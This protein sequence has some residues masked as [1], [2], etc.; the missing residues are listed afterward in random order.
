[1]VNFDELLNKSLSQPQNLIRA[2]FSGVNM[3]NLPWIKV[4]VR[5]VKIKENLVWQF[6]YFDQKKD[7][8]KNFDSNEYRL[9][10]SELVSS[11]F[12]N[13]NIDTLQEV[14]QAT[15]TK[16]GKYL[17]NHQFKNE[18]NHKPD[19]SHDR[20]KNVILQ[21]DKD[22]EFLRAINVVNTLG[23]IKNSKKYHQLNEFLKLVKESISSDYLDTHPTINIIDCGCGNAYL[24]FAL[25]YYFSQI[26]HHQV[27]VIGIDVNQELISRH[28]T[29]VNAL[30]WQNLD[31]VITPIINYQ[32]DFI[33]DIVVALHACDTATDDCLYQAVNWGSQY[34]FSVPCCH[35]HIQAQL[36]HNPQIVE[37]KP[38]LDYG[39]L[40]ERFGD[41][42]TDA[43]RVLLL[44][45]KN[46]KTDIVQF[47][48]PEHTSKNL[49]IRAIKTTKIAN[50]LQLKTEFD[51]FKKF[52]KVSPYLEKLL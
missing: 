5:P 19:L 9:K 7:I 32:P 17:F 2:V 51:N 29:Q 45:L 48:D 52:I 36:D 11:Q 16:S 35:H 13:I 28:K 43:F 14:I 10:I 47:I 34:I 20:Q 24:T 46:Y 8:T 6:S 21:P 50:S 4:I 39:V 18:I 22:A 31:F 41:L 12:K 25:Y 3:K 37:L 23:N 49:M 42:V 15:R 26:L 38:I 30:G 40:K 44:K 1:M 33:P 27:K